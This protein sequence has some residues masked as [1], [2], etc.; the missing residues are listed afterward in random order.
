M[1]PVL[2]D[3]NVTKKDQYSRYELKAAGKIWKD[4]TSYSQKEEKIPRQ[5]DTKFGDIRVTIMFGSLW[6]PGKWS[7]DCNDI[8]L[9]GGMN[10]ETPTQAAEIAV[11]QCAD[12]L[13]KQLQ[14]FKDEK[15]Y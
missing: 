9:Q 6:Y 13:S 14:Y 10:A 12:H 15:D 7:F 4:C 1:K 5:F 2:E 8:G 3:P 11:Q